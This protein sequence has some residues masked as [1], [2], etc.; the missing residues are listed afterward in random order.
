LGDAARKLIELRKRLQDEGLYDAQ[1]RLEA[2]TDYTRIAVLCPPGAAG[3]GDFKS[4]ADPLEASG[5]CRFDYVTATFQG[6]RTAAEMV[7]GLRSIYRAHRQ[8]PYDALIVLRGGGA[9]ADL[10]WLNDYEIARA[11][12]HMPMPVLTAIGHERD[13]IILDEIANQSIHTPSKAIG[14]VTAT[15]CDNAQRALA[16]FDAIIAAAS[17][18]VSLRQQAIDQA[19][20]VPHDCSRQHMRIA[21]DTLT[22]HHYTVVA[23]ARAAIDHVALL[24]DNQANQLAAA[25]RR[26]Y[27]QVATILATD[28]EAVSAG[29][30]QAVRDIGHG[31]AQSREI[32]RGRVVKDIAVTE[33]QI[34]VHRALI[35][36]RSRLGHTLVADQVTRVADQVAGQARAQIATV[37]ADLDGR[38][39][40]I[41]DRSRLSVETIRAQIKAEAELVIGFGPKKTLQ[42]GFVMTRKK[43]KPLTRRAQLAS[44]ERIELQFADGNIG[45][46]TD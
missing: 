6:E 4:H 30:R 18:T 21:A 10:A 44:G 37:V 34:D 1:R 9:Q 36:D 42:R 3:L 5:L 12:A 41:Q 29:A 13:M 7:D 45:A 24:L 46:T 17:A 2:P 35:R 43:G 39:S 20:A 31:L 23:G 19:R 14:Q 25:A 38:R 16:D 32:I 40:L 11:I 8:S 33:A 27:T 28:A 22:G 15:I 26:Q